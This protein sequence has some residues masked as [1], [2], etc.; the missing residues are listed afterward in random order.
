MKEEKCSE[1][2]EAQNR[3]SALWK[4]IGFLKGVQAEA[5]GFESKKEGVTANQHLQRG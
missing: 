4:Q 3:D 2:A 5:S 1:Q